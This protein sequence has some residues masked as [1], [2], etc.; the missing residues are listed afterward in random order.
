M[1]EEY[2]AYEPERS[3]FVTTLA[4]IFIVIT[5]L[6]T[7]ALI[8]QNVFFSFIYGMPEVKDSLNEQVSQGNMPELMGFIFSHMRV[9]L[10]CSLAASGAA[11]TAAIGLLM[12][13]NWARILFII[14]MILAIAWQVFGF[15]SQWFIIPEIPN[16]NPQVGMNL[17][18]VIMFARV[19]SF[20]IAAGFCFL[21]GWIVYKLT[22]ERIRREFMTSSKN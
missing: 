18:L 4:I 14:I 15:V 8:F 17:N 16:T 7:T 11:L 6:A 2:E 13:K 12:R 3:A 22:S 20:F 21:F 19:F 5:G 10:L 1:I 9:F